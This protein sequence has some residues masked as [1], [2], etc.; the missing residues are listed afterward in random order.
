MDPPIAFF[1]QLSVSSYS[2][3]PLEYVEDKTS[4]RTRVRFVPSSGPELT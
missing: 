3:K 1:S 2:S 4:G